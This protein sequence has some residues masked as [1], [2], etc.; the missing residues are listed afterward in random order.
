MGTSALTIV[1]NEEKQPLFNMYSQSDGYPSGVGG[2]LKEFLTGF[3]IIN[4]ISDYNVTKTANGM[5]CLAAQIVAHF[6]EGIGR[7]YLVP[8]VDKSDYEYNYTIYKGRSNKNKSRPEHLR[9]RVEEGSGGLLYDG[10]VRYFQPDTPNLRNEIKRKPKFSFKTASTSE[11]LN[12]LADMLETKYADVFN[13]WDIFNCVIGIGHRLADDGSIVGKP[14]NDDIKFMELYGIT[15][16]ETVALNYGT[17]S[18]LEIGIEDIYSG[19]MPVSKVAGVIR[20]L[21]A[22][23]KR[24]GN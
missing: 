23:Y 2:R 8:A 10:S 20:K 11:K 22:K 13:Q 3:K 21:A 5:E 14:N 1:L 17:Y 9:I 6:K 18:L 12:F 24:K 4:G 15:R 16:S 7:E 19:K